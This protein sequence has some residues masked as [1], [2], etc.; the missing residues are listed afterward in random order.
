MNAIAGFKQARVIGAFRK[1]A[2][3]ETGEK[4]HVVTLPGRI[5]AP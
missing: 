3:E 1:K 2:G 4:H 5:S